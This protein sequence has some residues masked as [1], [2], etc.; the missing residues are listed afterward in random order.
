MLWVLLEWMRCIWLELAMSL[1]SV[2]DCV[3]LTQRVLEDLGEEGAT[4]SSERQCGTQLQFKLLKK[5]KEKLYFN[6]YF[7]LYTFFKK[8]FFEPLGC[9]RFSSY[10]FALSSHTEQTP[11]KK[12]IPCQKHKSRKAKFS[13][14]NCNRF[15][16]VLTLS[17][18][19]AVKCPCW[20]VHAYAY[21]TIHFS[22]L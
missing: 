20:N 14:I 15:Q 12:T 4:R 18:S 10:T 21:K 9:K 11:N 3:W 7:Y 16:W 1:E 6:F 2:V 5:K 17:L 19:Q 8:S 13:V 22:A